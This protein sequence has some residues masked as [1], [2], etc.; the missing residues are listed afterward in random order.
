MLNFLKKI[1]LL[2]FGFF[3]IA[4]F[5]WIVFPS[6][7][8]AVNSVADTTTTPK[9]SLGEIFVRDFLGIP[10]CGL[11]GGGC[12]DT[13]PSQNSTSSI[14]A[15]FSNPDIQ[16]VD[17]HSGAEVVNSMSLQ[18]FA[19]ATWF[20]QGI[21]SADVLNEKNQKIGAFTLRSDSNSNTN[22]F[23]AFTGTIT[24]GDPGTKTGYLVF[25]KANPTSDPKKDSSLW[26]PVRFKE[27]NSGSSFL[28]P[29][30]Q[31]ECRR[32]GCSGQICSDSDIITTCEY[33][34]EFTCFQNARCERQQNG[35]CG[36]TQ[37]SELQSCLS[38]SGGNLQ[39][40]Q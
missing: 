6:S 8:K 18:G 3:V 29:P 16:I 21:A 10:K 38:A 1:G 26:L 36:F 2:A 30:G 33:R 7:Q 11:L 5:A 32:T 17:P 9:R 37:T 23:V 25:K 35:T 31:S 22:A 14:N 34:A 39:N 27:T 4:L 12:S 13:F 20:A 15:R 19:R 24:Y 40:P 28:T